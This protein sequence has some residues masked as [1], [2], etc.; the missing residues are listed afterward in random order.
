MKPQSDPRPVAL[1]KYP[2][3]TFM[4]IVQLEIGN[5]FQ[6]PLLIYQCHFH[7]LGLYSNYIVQIICLV[8]IC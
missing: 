8:T 1:I 2:R 5:L 6:Y 4:V 3:L 7:L